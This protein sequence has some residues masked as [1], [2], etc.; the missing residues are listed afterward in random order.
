MKKFVIGLVSFLL[1]SQ[2]VLANQPFSSTQECMVKLDEVFLKVKNKKIEMSSQNGTEIKL[3]AAETVG[4]CRSGEMDSAAESYQKLE[5]MISSFD[6]E[7][8]SASAAKVGNCADRAN[9]LTMHLM[10]SNIPKEIEGLLKED[11][12]R[13]EGTC[14]SGFN[15]KAQKMHTTIEG[16][17]S[18]MKGMG[19]N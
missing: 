9:K 16:T 3:Q 7:P 14:N 15:D 17:I 6:N 1:F 8:V 2:P 18:D 11:T 12:T 19:T 13:M 4:K 5:N 10:K